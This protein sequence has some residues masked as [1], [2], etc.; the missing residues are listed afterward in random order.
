MARWATALRSVPPLIAM[1][2]ALLTVVAAATVAIQLPKTLVAK[3][4]DSLGGHQLAR[5]IRIS[6]RHPGAS[7]FTTFPRALRAAMRQ[8][9]KTALERVAKVVARYVGPVLV[10]HVLILAAIEFHCSGV[11]TACWWYRVPDDSSMRLA[12]SFESDFE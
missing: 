5:R 10:A 12:E 7:R 8:G 2:F 6:L 11:G 9:G 3:I 4:A 1:P